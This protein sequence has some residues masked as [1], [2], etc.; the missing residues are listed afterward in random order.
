MGQGHAI[1]VLARAFYHSGGDQKYLKAALNGL[2]PFRWVIQCCRLRVKKVCKICRVVSS[3]G[4][5]LA[6][7]LNKYHW[8]EEYPTQ[9]ASFV[10]NGFIFS[11]LGLY[12][13]MSTAPFDQSQVSFSGGH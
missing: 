3:D 11:L 8:Y 6:T 7:F 13:L 10:L 1:S 12:D 2:K 9:P 5:V 4:G